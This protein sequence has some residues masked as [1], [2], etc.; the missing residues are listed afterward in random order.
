MEQ[1]FRVMEYAGVLLIFILVIFINPSIGSS[2][3]N[4]KFSS[5]GYGLF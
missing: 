2:F 5:A 4:R 3:E 1:Q